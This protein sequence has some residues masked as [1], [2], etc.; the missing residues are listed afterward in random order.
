MAWK[1]GFEM[2]PNAEGIM[3]VEAVS[4]LSQLLMFPDDTEV[5]IVQANF[6]PTSLDAALA[7]ETVR[8]CDDF[9]Q[10]VQ[11]LIDQRVVSTI[12]FIIYVLPEGFVPDTIPAVP[13]SSD[14]PKG[15]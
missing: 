15:D 2:N 1:K 14:T 6:S 12:A 9:R 4:D 13:T 8:V 11:T 7:V 5:A 3:K 10:H